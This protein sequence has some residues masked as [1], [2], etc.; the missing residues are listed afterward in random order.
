MDNL[1][2]ELIDA[3]VELLR[4]PNGRLDQTSLKSCCLVA[5][6]FREPCQRRILQYLEMSCEEENA[7]GGKLTL[8]RVAACLARSPHLASY[9][10]KLYVWVVPRDKASRWDEGF[11]A[12]LLGRLTNV[13]VC[14][15]VCAY[16]DICWND[17]PV[18]FSAAVLDW[19]T[20][21]R[22]T[23]RVLGIYDQM[24]DIP[25]PALHRIFAAAP[26]LRLETSTMEQGPVQLSD[27]LIAAEGLP[28]ILQDLTLVDD[29]FTAALV[30]HPGFAR[31]FRNLRS[32][33]LSEPFATL[34]LLSLAA[35]TLECLE[36]RYEDLHR[37][38][39]SP[40][41]TFPHLP[42]LSQLTIAGLMIGLGGPQSP[43]GAYERSRA[44]LTTLGLNIPSLTHITF[45]ILTHFTA[46]LIQH[47]PTTCPCLVPAA[48][49]GQLD[50]VLSAHPTLT[51]VRV[52]LQDAGEVKD[53][54][55]NG[56]EAS[57]KTAFAKVVAKG[58]LE[59]KFE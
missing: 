46:R 40:P 44:S 55:F 34:P 22:G 47:H 31:Y 25:L 21:Q 15:L 56:F 4:L 26:K 20:L 7:S 49:L 19:L 18:G 30:R 54:H 24:A 35:G 48:G 2:P 33:V 57:L 42:R 17:L 1:A 6:A 43:P 9:V 50:D 3:I 8:A 45:Q 39:N 37:R 10:T 53:I 38:G 59:V 16:V 12:E 41:F 32:V 11:P 58:M 36:L 51:A 27:V 13:R 52:T 23:M 29:P 28:V 5:S 14:E